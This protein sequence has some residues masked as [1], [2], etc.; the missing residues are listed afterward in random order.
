MAAVRVSRHCS[1]RPCPARLHGHCI[2]LAGELGL[3]GAALR[4]S[5]LL[6]PGQGAAVPIGT[7]PAGQVGDPAPR[8]TPSQEKSSR[9][10]MPG[11]GGVTFPIRSITALTCSDGGLT[12]AHCSCP[13][14]PSSHTQARSEVRRKRQGAADSRDWPLLAAPRAGGPLCGAAPACPSS[15]CRSQAASRST[16]SPS[17]RS[18]PTRTSSATISLCRYEG[19]GP[20]VG[21]GVSGDGVVQRGLRF[22]AQDSSGWVG[23]GEGDRPR[24]RVSKSRLSLERNEGSSQ[25]HSRTSIP[26]GGNS[27]DDVPEEERGGLERLR[28]N[29]GAQEERGEGAT[30]GPAG[31][32]WGFGCDSA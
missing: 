15:F 19:R 29:L 18:S 32:R 13:P 6:D 3:A 17:A 1:D 28:R 30:Q 25:V 26:G 7:G 16:L 21:V 2:R 23:G 12:F 20:R 10:P 9:H 31:Q 5:C 11:A 22:T 27:T 4:C 24:Q 8:L 14:L